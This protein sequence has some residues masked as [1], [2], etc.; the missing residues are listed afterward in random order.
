MIKDLKVF[1]KRR[2]LKFKKKERKKKTGRDV[3]NRNFRT[4]Q[5]LPTA[6]VPRGTKPGSVWVMLPPGAHVPRP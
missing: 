1:K 5:I 4:E 2:S 6:D 3:S